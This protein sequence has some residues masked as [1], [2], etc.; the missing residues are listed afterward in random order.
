MPAFQGVKR[1]ILSLF[2]TQR[3]GLPL[4]S[5]LGTLDVIYITQTEVWAGGEGACG[6]ESS[7][8]ISA[9]FLF[10]IFWVAGKLQI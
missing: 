3:S 8:F 1:R 4:S 2:Q 9:L 7:V 6:G 5:F 10:L